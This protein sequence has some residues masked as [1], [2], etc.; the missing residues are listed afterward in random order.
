ML[1][2]LCLAYWVHLSVNHRFWRSG[3]TA[4]P[5]SSARWILVIVEAQ[6][7]DRVG[8]VGS[9]QI[10]ECPCEARREDEVCPAWTAATPTTGLI[11]SSPSPP[12]APHESLSLPLLVPSQPSAPKIIFH[13][14][15]PP[16]NPP[17]CS[18]TALRWMAPSSARRTGVTGMRVLLFA[19]DWLQEDY[20]SQAI[21][22]WSVTS[23]SLDIVLYRIG[24]NMFKNIAFHF[25]LY[26][27]HFCLN[28]FWVKTKNAKMRIWWWTLL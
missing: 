26:N 12:G 19:G 17:A 24:K 2:V 13:K 25:R 11:K 27:T 18:V 22:S 8:R 16:T 3:L 5:R 1:W 28:R 4:L 10:R 15:N 21:S 23:W 20:H 14:V 7:S 6:G 9:P